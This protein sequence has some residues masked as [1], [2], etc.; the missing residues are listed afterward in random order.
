M[1]LGI[2]LVTVIAPGKAVSPAVAALIK[3]QYLGDAQARIQQGAQAT[4][5]I[6]MLVDIVSKG[7]NYLLNVGPTPE[8]TIPQPCIPISTMIS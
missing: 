3:A 1:L 2:F 6:Q 7:G 4:G 8:G 5:W